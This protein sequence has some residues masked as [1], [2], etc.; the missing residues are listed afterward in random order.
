MDV[1][2]RLKKILQDAGLDKHGVVQRIARDINVHRHTVGKL[3]RNTVRNPS[4]EVVGRLCDWLRMEGVRVELPQALFGASP[5][6]LWTAVVAT[7]EVRIYLGEYQ[8][9][10]GDADL[11]WLSPWDAAVLAEFFHKLSEPSAGA[12]IRPALVS[13]FVPFRS[14]RT[15]RRVT[16]EASKKQRT[17]A[18][19]MFRGLRRRTEGTAIL[20]GSQR[21][22]R[23]V[24]LMIADLFGCTG[25]RPRQ[26]DARVPIYVAYRPEDRR[27]PS[28]FGGQ[29]PPSGNGGRVKPG[30][31]YEDPD[32]KWTHCPCIPEKR[33]A[34]VVVT[35]DDPGTRVL[36]VALFGY[37]GTGT[38]AMGT[39]LLFNPGNF[40][41]PYVQARGQRIGVYV[42]RFELQQGKLAGREGPVHAKHPEVIPLEK[43]T[44]EKYL[45][46]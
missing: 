31:L 32:G 3:Y 37:S 39:Q 41:P 17:A 9:S 34:G 27:V 43:A 30:I 40:W 28:C 16:R 7:G 15:G 20:I 1:E 12:D 2:I 46:R 21:I 23:L 11:R 38:A 33:D 29:A 25:F 35:V 4:L 24:E 18:E 45:A 44:L 22:N 36:S 14:E 6:D 19:R 26:G 13:E 42:C 10:A 5:A 8:E